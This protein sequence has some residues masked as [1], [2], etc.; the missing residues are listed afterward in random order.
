MRLFAD[1]N[2]SRGIVNWLRQSGHDV[3]YGSETS[4]GATDSTWLALA[5]AQQRLV[6]T[7]D[8]DFGELVFRNRLTTYGIIL[9]R[10]DELPLRERLARIQNAWAVVESNPAGKFIVITESRVRVRPLAS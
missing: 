2:V 3:T 8:K 10:L 7:S 4:P 6:I 1:E 5:E 9:L